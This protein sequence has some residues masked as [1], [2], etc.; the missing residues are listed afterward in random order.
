ME[1]QNSKPSNGR[2]YD[3]QSSYKN[4][5]KETSLEDVYQMSFQSKDLIIPLPSPNKSA[6]KSTSSV[7]GHGVHVEHPTSYLE[8][9]MHLLKGNVG[10]GIF[11]MGKAMKN[12]GIILGPIVVLL[13][14]IIC[15]YCQHILLNTAKR[16]SSGSEMPISPDYAETAELVFSKGPPRLQKYSKIMKRLVNIF[17]CVTQ[18]GFCCVYFVFVA[19]I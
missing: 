13:L 15:L 8:T 3:S 1:L 16:I 17:L 11:A 9:L 10:S 6:K 12:A 4:K 5:E 19:K 7:G 14:G 18:L 2:W